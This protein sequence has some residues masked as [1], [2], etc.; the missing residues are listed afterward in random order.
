MNIKPIILLCAGALLVGCASRPVDNIPSAAEAGNDVAVGATPG[1][2][3]IEDTT[4]TY[5]TDQNGLDGQGLAG[6]ADGS[7]A[8]SGPSFGSDTYF[9]REAIFDP[10][11]PL[12]DRIFYFAYDRDTLSDQ[13][14][15][16]I[17]DHGRYLA[18]YPDALVRLE[19]H[20]D[21]RGTREYNIA[22]AERRAQSVKRLMMLQG[23][24]YNQIITISYGEEQPAVLGQTEEAY[25]RN[26]R[27]ELVYE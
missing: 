5:G 24:S 17:T 3:A 26:R 13:Y 12:A 8:A 21:E 6:L 27:V 18:T 20:A 23:A 16:T 4:D 1:A 10:G 2:G 19:G 25:S 9:E 11:S 15:D 7:L 22:L 14:L